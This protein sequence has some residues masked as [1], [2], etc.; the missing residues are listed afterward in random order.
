MRGAGGVKPL[1]QADHFFITHMQRRHL[2]IATI[3]HREIVAVRIARRHPDR[4]KR[5][6]HR[7]RGR[8][9]FRE[10]PMF[11]VVRVIAGPQ[12]LDRRNKFAHLLPGCPGI[13]TGAHP[14]IFKA[15]GPARDAQIKAA[16]HDQIGHRGLTRQFDRMPERGD[17]IAGAKPN[18]LGAAREVHQI[19]ERVRRDGEIHAVMLAGPDR[20]HAVFVSNLAEFQHFLIQSLLRL[21]GTDPLHMHEQRKLHGVFP[22]VLVATEAT[23]PTF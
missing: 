2:Y 7:F 5:L 4:R 22:S 15:V 23:R 13:Q 11:A 14:F 12:A 19:Q 21:I 3:G 6:L 17:H 20:M 1:H 8:G 16:V 18:I 9:G 10:L